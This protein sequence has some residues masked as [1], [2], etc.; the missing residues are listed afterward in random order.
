MSFLAFSPCIISDMLYLLHTSYLL[1][2]DILK[3]HDVTIYAGI[4]EKNF[5]VRANVRIVGLLMNN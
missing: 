5:M 3:T 4:V 1:Y 2:G